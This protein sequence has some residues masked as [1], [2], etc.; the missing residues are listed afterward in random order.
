MGVDF[1][2]RGFSLGWARFEDCTFERCRTQHLFS[3]P[4]DLVGC[5]SVGRMDDAQFLGADSAT[6]IPNE[7]EG[8]D[9]TGAPL[10]RVSFQSGARPEQ[11]L[12]PAGV[13][14]EGDE[15]SW[16]MVVTAGREPPTP[17]E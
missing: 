8:N 14:A 3:V 13:V 7:V 1:G 4:S 2:V 11:Q 16:E 9:F 15:S 12:W 17:G 10:G 5:R 6:G